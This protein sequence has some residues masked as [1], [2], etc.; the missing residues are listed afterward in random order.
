MATAFRKRCDVRLGLRQK[1]GTEK[2]VARRTGQ[3][4]SGGA[5][6]VGGRD[7]FGADAGG[8]RHQV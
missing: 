5:C 7:R 1:T 3:A 8:E 6:P 4:E 2:Q